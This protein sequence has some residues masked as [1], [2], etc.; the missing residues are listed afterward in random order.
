MKTLSRFFAILND[1][2]SYTPTLLE[3]EKWKNLLA[4][5]LSV[6]P[7]TFALMQKK[8]ANPL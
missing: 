2:N 5:A 6:P 3:R 1:I 4:T 7:Q 8:T